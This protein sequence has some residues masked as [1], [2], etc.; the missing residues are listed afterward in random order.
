MKTEQ[1][2]LDFTTDHAPEIGDSAGMRGYQDDRDMLADY[3]RLFQLKLPVIHRMQKGFS[4]PGELDHL[5][6]AERRIEVRLHHSRAKGEGG[7]L[8][9][10]FRKFK[11]PPQ[12]RMMV[13]LLCYMEAR[14]TDSMDAGDLIDVICDC[15]RVKMIGFRS[16]M[17]DEALVF[18]SGLLARN[19]TNE[20]F[21]GRDWISLGESVKA[22][23]FGLYER[24]EQP[25]KQEGRGDPANARP[26]E[27]VSSPRQIFDQLSRHVIGQEM[28]KQAIAVALYQHHLRITGKASVEKGNLMLVGPTG[29]GKT[30]LAEIAARLLGVPF[31]TADATQ[32]TELGYVGMSMEDLFKAL[33]K[34]SGENPAKAAQGIIFL[35]E[36]DKIAASGEGGIR[37]TNRDISGECVQQDLLRAIEGGGAPGRP[38]QTGDIMF[39]AGGAFSGLRQAMAECAAPIGFGG[40]EAG[41]PQGERQPGLEDFVAYGMLPELMGRFQS[42]VLLDPLDRRALVRILAEPENSLVSQYVK[43]F[44]G[45]GVEL[46]I[47]RE[48][49][50][51]IAKKAEKQG[52]G[53]RALKSVLGAVLSPLLFSAAGQDGAKVVTVTSGM[54]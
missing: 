36:I 52:T 20:P 28:A 50:E 3:F 54:V 11:L 16:R 35:D 51:A 23:V 8:I 33:Y 30:Y 42:V 22:H 15:D 7:W 19:E 21:L 14:H 4:R 41:R 18:K 13:A 49:L 46:K 44:A 40:R 24:C 27:A 47:P 12:E 10:Q 29:C 43:M 48:T 2:T 34:A 37:R 9:T 6:I 53:A 39:I 38:F 1:Q 32:L 17:T 5:R 25:A 31:V 45:L 26:M